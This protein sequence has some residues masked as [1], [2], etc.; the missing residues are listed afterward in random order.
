MKRFA[1]TANSLASVDKEIMRV[2]GEDQGE[3]PQKARKYKSR[4]AM[5][6]PEKAEIQGG[7]LQGN[8]RHE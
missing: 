6:K 1:R 4:T 5:D 2:A 8:R 7:Y 3:P